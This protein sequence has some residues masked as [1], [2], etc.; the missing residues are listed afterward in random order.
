MHRLQEAHGEYF[1][2]IILPAKRIR[3]RGSLASHKNSSPH[4]NSILFSQEDREIRFNSYSQ[5]IIG[6]E[7]FNPLIWQVHSTFHSTN[8]ANLGDKKGGKKKTWEKGGKLVTLAGFKVVVVFF[9]I[10]SQRPTPPGDYFGQFSWDINHIHLTVRCKRLSPSSSC[11]QSLGPA[12]KAKVD[13]QR[14]RR[15]RE[16]VS[17]GERLPAEF[18]LRKVKLVF[19]WNSS[20]FRHS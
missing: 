2:F 20:S 17:M 11:Q 6:R 12:A 13:P 8:A 15:E 1:I 3:I 7:T 19:T 14:G 5:Q 10:K 4:F 18:N 16:V 9:F